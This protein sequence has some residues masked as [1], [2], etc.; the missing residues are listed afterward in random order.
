MSHASTSST[1]RP[2]VPPSSAAP[3]PVTPAPITTRSTGAAL[4]AA[5]SRLRWA[6]ISQVGSA[7]SSAPGA[8][9]RTGSVM[10]L[11]PQG[12]VVSWGWG[13]GG[14]TG[15]VMALFRQVVLASRQGSTGST[16]VGK[17]LSLQVAADFFGAQAGG[18]LDGLDRRAG[19]MR[20]QRHVRVAQ[21]RVG[22]VARLDA[23]GLQRGA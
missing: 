23:E 1:A 19:D 6:G 13:G 11:F 9:G 18:V 21:Q 15:A 22:R 3:A 14:R 7:A 10:A 8:R 16:G 20:R 5:R 4:A 12:W 2:R 17:G